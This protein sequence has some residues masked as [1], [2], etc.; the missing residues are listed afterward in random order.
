[1]LSCRKITLNSYS[2]KTRVRDPTSKRGRREDEARE[3]RAPIIGL[4]D[5]TGSEKMLV[6]CD[7]CISCKTGIRMA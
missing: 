5:A 7:C 4:I 2:G 6:E 3:Y 1:M